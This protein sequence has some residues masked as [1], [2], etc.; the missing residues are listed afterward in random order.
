MLFAQ[1]VKKKI[2]TYCSLVRCF[3]K[4]IKIEKS[5]IYF[6]FLPN[7]RFWEF[8][9]VARGENGVFNKRVACHRATA[10]AL[11]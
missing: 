2:L 5:K 4:Y 6:G 3:K 11:Y 1:I 7:A 10:T 9:L 8:A